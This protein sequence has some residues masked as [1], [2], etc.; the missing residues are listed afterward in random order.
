MNLI[1]STN[2]T[3]SAIAPLKLM[4]FLNLQAHHVVT[5]QIK[6]FTY[7]INDEFNMSLLMILI[8]L[9]TMISEMLFVS[10][11]PKRLW[12]L[13]KKA[14]LLLLIHRECQLVLVVT[15]CE[16]NVSSNWLT[17]LRVS[18]VQKLKIFSTYLSLLSLSNICLAG[19]MKIQLSLVFRP[20]FSHYLKPI[21]Y[22]W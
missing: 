17:E 13:F 9:G 21:I 16:G 8:L 12:N 1:W 14:C 2:Q 4:L 6:C 3:E 11:I 18:L 19:S 5:R 7:N 20:F 10:L 15:S 22:L